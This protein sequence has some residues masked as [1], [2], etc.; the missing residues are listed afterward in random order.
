MKEN[1][2]EK[3]LKAWKIWNMTHADMPLSCLVQRRLLSSITLP[4]GEAERSI[5]SQLDLG[6][7]RRVLVGDQLGVMLGGWTAD[8]QRTETWRVGMLAFSER[9]LEPLAIGG[10]RWSVSTRTASDNL[11]SAFAPT[12]GFPD[13]G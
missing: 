11:R 10:G 9:M 8:A 1:L 2:E 5:A 12:V 13:L 7:S 3:F 4:S 6:L